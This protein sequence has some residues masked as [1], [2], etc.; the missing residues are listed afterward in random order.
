MT[1]PASLAFGARIVCECRMPDAVALYTALSTGSELAT[2]DEALTA[3]AR[4]AGV[5]VA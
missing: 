5:V 2:F 4:Q 3:A 1:R